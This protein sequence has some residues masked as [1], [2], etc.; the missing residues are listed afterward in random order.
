LV[1]EA[2]KKKAEEEKILLAED[3]DAADEAAARA[4][5]FAS[6]SDARK[7]ADA[8]KAESDRLREIAA[9]EAAAVDARNAAILEAAK[10]KAKADLARI[11]EELAKVKKKI[12]RKP[13]VVTGGVTTPAQKIE[14]AQK[15]YSAAR[16]RLEAST[17]LVTRASTTFAVALT[18]ITQFER[19]ISNIEKSLVNNKNQLKS[20]TDSLNL[21]K[22]NE[23]VLVKKVNVAREKFE[24]QKNNAA[25]A[26][27]R[28]L[29]LQAKV[30]QSKVTAADARERYNRAIGKGLVTSE[31]PFTVSNSE[32]GSDNLTQSKTEINQLREAAEKAEAQYKADLAE[33]KTA[34]S[35]AKKTQATFIFA[36]G[37]L[38]LLQKELQLLTAK[39][40]SQIANVERFRL[41]QDVLIEKKN[42]VLK[43]LSSAKAASIT[44]QNELTEVQVAEQK[45]RVQLARREANLDTAKKDA[46]YADKVNDAKEQAEKDVN[47][48]EKDVDGA[49]ES[50]N[51]ITTVGAA[52]S[53]LRSLP[54]IFTIVG[55][56]AVV[57]FLAMNAVKRS[58]RKGGEGELD[59]DEFIGSAKFAPV[60]KKAV[61]KKAVAK[62]AV[63][64]K[65]VAKKAVAKK[66]V[67]KKAVAKKAVA[68]K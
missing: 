14:V 2:A 61:A 22:K 25:K 55:V 40:E 47:Q 38:E 50:V 33:V 66:A 53:S 27:A 51:E 3:R 36:Q 68:K 62:K 43:N 32:L 41:Q 24:L 37:S 15:D 58:R 4:A 59:I 17:T 46:A 64:K 65:A 13:Q 48:A 29:S 12:T 44:A 35:L 57:A 9:Q 8:A 1:A 28:S 34:I 52:T 7:A 10:E 56:V 16:D 19:Q 63:A 42:A 18:K 54:L 5:T 39:K 60:A 67:A 30:A 21:T 23:I 6:D 26:A 11:K 49:E 20:A 45:A 31:K